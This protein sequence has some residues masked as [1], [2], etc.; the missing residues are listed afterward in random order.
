VHETTTGRL[1]TGSYK[2]SS[3]SGN[4]AQLV[5]WSFA[6]SAGGKARKSVVIY[7]LID[8]LNTVATRIVT[9]KVGRPFDQYRGRR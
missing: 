9:R 8:G 1:A 5:G 7:P 3:A 6:A 4:T 2:L